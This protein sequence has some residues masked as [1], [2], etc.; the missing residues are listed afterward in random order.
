MGNSPQFQR[1][2][3]PG[4]IG[5]METRNRIVMPAMSSILGAKEGF[6][7]D[8]TKD[9]YEA[10]AKGGVGTIMVGSIAVDYP[11]GITGKPRLSI[12]DDKYL[13]GL[14][15]VVALIHKHGAKAVAQ[16]HHG[17]NATLQNLTGI[18]PVA[19]S[20]IL[21]RTSYMRPVYFMPRE[22]TVKEIHELTTRFAAAAERAKRAG[23]DGVEVN[24][25][26]RYLL[27]T[28]LST[29]WNRRTDQYGGDLKNRARF[30]LE[31][32][33]SMRKAVGSDYPVIIR[34]NGVEHEVEGYTLE[35]AKEVSRLLEDAGV[36]AIN[37]SIYETN[38]PS[39]PPGFAVHLAAAIKKTVSVPVMAV[40]AIGPELGEKVLREKKADFIC[41]GRALLA[42]PELPNKAVSG[43]VE[44]I[45]PCLRCNSCLSAPIELQ[46]REG[47]RECTVN[48]SLTKE[49]EY[50]IKPAAKAKRVLV[51]GGGPGGMEA[52]RVAALRGHQ[53]LLYEKEKRLGGQLNL[54]CML[55]EENGALTKYLT[56][57]MKKLGVKVELG[58]EV[59]AALVNEL[60]PDVIVAATGAT[61]FVPEIPGADGSNVLSGADIHDMLQGHRGEKG[62][63]GRRFIWYIG[64]TLMKSPLGQRLMR[65]MLRLWAPFG[66]R[67]VVV[68]RGLPGIELA[69]F[70][71]ERGKRV[72]VVDTREDLVFGEPPMPVVR[73][74]ME[75][76]LGEEGTA[77]V[78]AIEIEKV[79]DEGLTVINKKGQRQTLEGDTV[80]FAAEY[81]P[82]NELAQ[83]LVG[84]P[85]EVHLVGD[86]NKP[87]GILEA[88][89][90]GS[91][92]GRAI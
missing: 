41:M 49:R 81:K 46:A 17:G 78:T 72:I 80:V 59:D 52:A 9:Y 67:V 35:T 37:V 62:L 77:M 69:H 8:L 65:R 30:L 36:D 68:G 61:A 45:T 50:E 34:I 1:L 71:V 43:R 2:F 60:K 21:R 82:N 55:R 31:I 24:A 58:K 13:P 54:A 73:Q 89:R 33:A 83:M 27:H 18:Q 7:T 10:R 76:K 64:L 42:D 39:Y 14:A 70:L 57:Q 75:W 47:L 63:K 26:H 91:R 6:A 44:D 48:A 25:A 15:E 29:Y 79:T 66:K 4:R 90:D 56:T 11:A 88:I 20:P 84:T 28:F 92:V 16:L 23:F 22:I 53:V 40:G 5:K 3:E 85:Y 38:T 12:D 74:L 32:I 87:V 86:C 19:P 51:I